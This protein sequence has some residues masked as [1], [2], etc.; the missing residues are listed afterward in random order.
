MDSLAT[1]RSSRMRFPEA[2]EYP[3]RH[4]YRNLARSRNF[5][6]WSTGRGGLLLGLDPVHQAP[7]DDWK[8]LP[9][10]QKLNHRDQWRGHCHKPE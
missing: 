1:E 7:I 2:A 4:L 6:E 9:E 10:Y 3:P 8:F 5:S